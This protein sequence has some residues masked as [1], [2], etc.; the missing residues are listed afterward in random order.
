MFGLNNRKNPY[1]AAPAN[2]AVNKILTYALILFILYGFYIAKNN[3]DRIALAPAKTINYTPIDWSKFAL[4]KNLVTD[5]QYIQALNN[6]SLT[7]NVSKDDLGKIKSAKLQNGSLNLYE[8]RLQPKFDINT[9]IN[10]Q[11]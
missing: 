2:R 1:P 6:Y 5:E 4:V 9:L 7:L 11:Q 10:P 8:I 3:G